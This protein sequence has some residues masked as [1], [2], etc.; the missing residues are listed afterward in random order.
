MLAKADTWIDLTRQMIK[1]QEET[2]RRLAEREEA[3]G[4]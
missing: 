1:R 4:L 2:N 3:E